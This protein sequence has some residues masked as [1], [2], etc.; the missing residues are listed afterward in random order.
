[1]VKICVKFLVNAL[2]RGKISQRV[3]DTDDKTVKWGE[4]EEDFENLFREGAIFNVIGEYVQFSFKKKLEY[5]NRGRFTNIVV[6]IFT[7]AHAR[8]RLYRAM[9]AVG[10]ENV[11]YCDT[12]SLVFNQQD[13]CKLLLG[14]YLGDLTDET[15][16]DPIVEF[17]AVAPK[18]YAL[19]QASGNT[20]V[21][22]KGTKEKPYYE[23]VKQR[24]LDDSN[25]PI[26]VS[27]TQF[28]K[29]SQGRM[30]T[31][32][33]KKKVTYDSSKAK[34]QRVGFESIPHYIDGS[35]ESSS[36]RYDDD[37]MDDQINI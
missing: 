12:D 22:C 36:S 26:L 37:S 20:K 28:R 15:A 30:Y 3:Y 21:V 25:E 35:D 9:L 32:K 13:E 27:T 5:L 31:A 2:G 8:M 16:D 17:V 24:V 7:T 33:V 19:K 10:L 6:G 34:R 29:N 4:L 14:S 1:M 18:T 23:D 11:I